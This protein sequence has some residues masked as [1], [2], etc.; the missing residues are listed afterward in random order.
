MCPVAVENK[1]QL[2]QLLLSRD[3]VSED[4]LKQA[5]AEQKEIVRRVEALFKLADAIEKRLAAANERAERL[6]QAILA[7]AFR[8]ELVPT[9]AELAKR[10]GRSYEPASDLLAK[11]GIF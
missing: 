8:G 2:G 3:V 7:K 11:V 9:E 6:T 10:E 1:M 4:Q 5:L